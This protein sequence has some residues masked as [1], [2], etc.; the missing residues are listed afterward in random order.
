MNTYRIIPFT[1]TGEIF[2][3]KIIRIVPDIYFKSES[4]EEYASLKIDFLLF[5]ISVIFKGFITK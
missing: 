2:F 4:H 1:V 3:H 5:Q